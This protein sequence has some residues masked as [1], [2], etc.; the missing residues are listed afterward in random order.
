MFGLPSLFAGKVHA[1]LFRG[2]KSRVKG[3]DLYDYIWYLSKEIDINIDHLNERIRRF[4]HAQKEDLSLQE[5]KG[6][7][8]NKF[9]KIDYRSAIDDV[10][11]FIKDDSWQ[12][13][14]SKDFFISITE[15]RLK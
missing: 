11:P 5:I 6:L 15:D 1:I 14:W 10:L 13:L 12:K 3:R 8:R 7:L 2:W 9:E 4:D